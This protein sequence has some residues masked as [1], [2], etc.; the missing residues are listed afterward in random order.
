MN[1]RNLAIAAALSLC[2]A[3]PVSAAT[4][5]LAAPMKPFNPVL[6]VGQLPDLVI[7]TAT[8]QRAEFCRPGAPVLYVTA[9]VQNV[10]HGTSA[11]EPS[12][13]MVQ[14]RESGGVNWGNGHGLPALAAG[15]T[16]S[17]TF[18]IYYLQSDPSHMQGS[19]T[20][21]L[22]V[23]AG[24]WVH[25]ADYNNDGFSPVHVAIPAGFCSLRPDITSR[26]GIRIG[27]RFARWGGQI[28]LTAKDAIGTGNG[29]CAFDIAYDMVDQG[30]GATHPAF[31]N[32]LR[33]NATVVSQQSGLHLNAGQSRLI[34]TQAYL[35][36]GEHVLGLSL[37]DGHAV[38]ES[39]EGNNLFR[40][41]VRVKS[42][43]GR[44]R[45]VSG[46]R[47]MVPAPQPR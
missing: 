8:I 1:K 22:T 27:H 41:N 11:A 39:N 30:A 34:H 4:V 47:L 44:R 42:A 32:R 7:R 6:K 46:A 12:V 18:P 37:D 10:G 14:A 28:N 24:K 40:I 17:V 45:S 26:K 31:V 38:A 3:A 23:N 25:E 9:R 15:A 2:A 5:R 20:F 33:Q 36:P 21:K 16:T 13:G 19:H 43:C 29:K 35:S